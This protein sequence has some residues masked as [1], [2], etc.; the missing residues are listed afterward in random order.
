MTLLA[1]PLTRGRA[2]GSVFPVVDRSDWT[3]RAPAG[4]V[5]IVPT[6]W[7]PPAGS[8]LHAVAGYVLDEEPAVPSN[9]PDR[10]VVAGLG[11]DLF[12]EGERIEV[13]A[14]AGR[15]RI[16]GV[17]EVEVVTAFLERSDRKI[18]LLR[19]SGRVGSF[20]GR[21]A[22]VSGFLEDRTALD[23]AFREIEEETGFGKGEL[24]LIARGSV[25]A[26]R[27][28]PTIYLVHPFLFRVAHSDYRLDWEH[29]EAEWVDPG[30]IGERATVPKLEKAWES[31]AR[32]RQPKS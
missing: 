5:L 18:L 16:D 30:A 22:G 10:P 24:T 31:V 21:W 1:K 19:R 13:D 8:N 29:T 7:W 9:L 26:A 12:R 14:D 4:G 11:Q 32:T 28:G 3:R 17:T 20:A 25:V 2:T 23:Q 6:G 27:S 15:V